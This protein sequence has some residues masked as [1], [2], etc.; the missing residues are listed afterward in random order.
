MGALPGLIV[1]TQNWRITSSLSP[2][3]FRLIN[4]LPLVTP[5]PHTKKKDFCLFD[6]LI[7]SMKN[8][9]VLETFLPKYVNSI[10]A[11]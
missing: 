1:Y 9:N 3:D 11:Q 6:N 4:L 7:P 5:L 8:I 2:E 10:S